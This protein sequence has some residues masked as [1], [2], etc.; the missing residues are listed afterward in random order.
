M[1]GELPSLEFSPSLLY[2]ASH[3]QFCAASLTLEYRRL[4][5]RENDLRL[6]MYSCCFVILLLVS[7]SNPFVGICTG[8]MVR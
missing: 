3:R 5:M 8:S 6:E 1:G 2:T 4:K 7:A